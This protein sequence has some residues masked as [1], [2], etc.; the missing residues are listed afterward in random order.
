VIKRVK[1]LVLK[2]IL[3]RDFFVLDCRDVT[4]EFPAEPGERF[5]FVEYYYRGTVY[6]H[7][8]KFTGKWSVHPRVRRLQEYCVER[9]TR[10]GARSFTAVYSKFGIRKL[11]RAHN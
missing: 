5:F 8:I 6:R 11:L 1:L 2:H 4:G 7:H 10:R 3:R 9:T